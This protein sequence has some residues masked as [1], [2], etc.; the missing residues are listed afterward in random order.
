MVHIAA[1][2]PILQH[3]QREKRMVEE[4]KRHCLT[5]SL[6]FVTEEKEKL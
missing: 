1:M 5:L 3:L 4:P 2:S 6:K